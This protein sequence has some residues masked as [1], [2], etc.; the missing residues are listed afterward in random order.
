LAR[1]TGLDQAHTHLPHLPPEVRQAVAE[2]AQLC[3]TEWL[4][5]AEQLDE[6]A[7]SSER[8]TRSSEQQPKTGQLRIVGT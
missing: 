4:H 5:F 8:Q 1:V 6:H 2:L 7:A 3:A